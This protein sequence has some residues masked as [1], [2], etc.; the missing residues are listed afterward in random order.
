MARLF[1]SKDIIIT[2]KKSI[3]KHNKPV[4]FYGLLKYDSIML[5]KLLCAAISESG[6]I[7]LDLVFAK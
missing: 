6:N 7:S 2:Q 3:D 4:T 1:G 5:S